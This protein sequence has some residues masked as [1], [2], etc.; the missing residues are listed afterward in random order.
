MEHTPTHEAL[1]VTNLCSTGN[2][3]PESRSQT[4]SV[5]IQYKPEFVT[6]AAEQEKKS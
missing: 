6:K 4:L 5:L 3:S 2:A 1:Y